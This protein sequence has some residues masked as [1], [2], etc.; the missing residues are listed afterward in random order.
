MKEREEGEGK[1]EPRE[2]RLR[3]LRKFGKFGR[4]AKKGEWVRE[5]IATTVK[6]KFTRFAK[7]ASEFDERG[8]PKI[9]K[10]DIEELVYANDGYRPHMEGEKKTRKAFF[11]RGAR[12]WR[13]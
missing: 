1:V 2:K 8:Q 7:S 12:V 10:V 5:S 6:R 9:V 11:W 4:E 13:E 3:E